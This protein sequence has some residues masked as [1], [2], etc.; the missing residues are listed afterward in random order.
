MSAFKL[1]PK[2][3]SKVEFKNGLGQVIATIL[4]TDDDR[5]VFNSTAN[6][7]ALNG[8]EQGR[9]LDFLLENL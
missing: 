4:K 9:L 7:Y 2:V 6:N 5:M 3:I 1:K 8:K